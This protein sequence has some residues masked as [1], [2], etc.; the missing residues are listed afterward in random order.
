M[1]H[2]NDGNDA[3]AA[4]P[5]LAQRPAEHDDTPNPPHRNILAR[6]P[7]GI[8]DRPHTHYPHSALAIPRLRSIRLQ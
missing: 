1:P 7:I 2:Q 8:L 3:E 6:S 5:R 4:T